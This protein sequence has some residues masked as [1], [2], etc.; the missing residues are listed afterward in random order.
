MIENGKRKTAA[1][2]AAGLLALSGPAASGCGDDNGASEDVENAADNAS[3]DVGNAADE[4]VDQ[5]DQ[6]ADDL[7]E[8]A[9]DAAN[10]AQKE[11]DGKEGN[12][13]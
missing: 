10:D 12:D 9:N 7:G 6:A 3:D 4:A 11:V 13:G 5:A 1:L 2:L 8:D